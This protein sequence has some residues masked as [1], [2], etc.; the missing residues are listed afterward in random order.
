L[1]CV[2][3]ITASKG[4]QNQ[5]VDEEELNDV[6][7]HS[8]ERNLQRPQMGVNA[9]DVHQLEKAANGTINVNVFITRGLMMFT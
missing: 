2:C 8:A 4:K 7:N 6:N 3:D 9:E 1:N 5:H